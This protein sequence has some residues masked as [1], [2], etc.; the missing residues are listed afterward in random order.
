MVY[1]VVLFSGVQPSDSVIP[2]ALLFQILFHYRLIQNIEWSSLCY[3]IG[4]C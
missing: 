1:N 4:P 3:I 2:I